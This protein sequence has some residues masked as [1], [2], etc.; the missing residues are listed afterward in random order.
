[1]AIKQDTTLAGDVGKTSMI[2][3]RMS[4]RNDR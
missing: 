2:A 1:M 4:L 3:G